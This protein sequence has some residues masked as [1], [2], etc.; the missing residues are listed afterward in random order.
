MG[1]NVLTICNV[2]TLNLRRANKMVKD[3]PRL[4][5]K[6]NEELVKAGARPYEGTKEVTHLLW[7][8][9]TE[10]GLSL[11]EAAGPA[12]AERP[13]GGARTTAASCCGRRR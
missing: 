2:C 8:L 3:D 13:A 4:L 7:Y 6:V 5:E 12:R 10:E 1:V 11:L 9:A